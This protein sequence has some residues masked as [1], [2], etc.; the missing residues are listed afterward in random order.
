LSKARK[1]LEVKEGRTN[2]EGFAVQM[3]SRMT[4]GSRLRHGLEGKKL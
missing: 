2:G 4:G 3:L 1:G